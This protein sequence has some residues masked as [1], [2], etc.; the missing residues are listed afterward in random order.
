MVSKQ[1]EQK[2]ESR[3][4]VK[5]AVLLV[6]GCVLLALAAV[7]AFL[8]VL[9]TTPFVLVAA[10]CFSHSSQKLHALLL[11]SRFFGEYIENYR[12]K[13]GVSMAVKV[14]SIIVLWLLLAVSAVTVGKLWLTLLL[15]AVGI[16]V[17]IH[18]LL[19]KTRPPE[20]TALAPRTKQ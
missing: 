5:R 4:R 11:R 6:C 17:T 20:N 7:G 1:P 19:L 3:A 10:V 8:P 13:R 9:P 2:T 12:S 18:L 15:A 16:G 14:R